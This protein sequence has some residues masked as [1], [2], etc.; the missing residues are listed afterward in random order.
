MIYVDFI[1]SWLL[2]WIFSGFMVMI[3]MFA[4][5]QSVAGTVE[6]NTRLALLVGGT[7]VI[8]QCGDKLK[9]LSKYEPSKQPAVKEVRV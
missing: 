9:E 4:V 1:F 2:P 5:W 3:G 7:A 6:R 8:L